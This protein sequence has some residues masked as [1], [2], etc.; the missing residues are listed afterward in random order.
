MKK[1]T[2]FVL[3]KQNPAEVKKRGLAKIALGIAFLQGLA[4][5]AEIAC[6]GLFLSNEFEVARGEHRFFARGDYGRYGVSYD[7]SWDLSAG[8]HGFPTR[9]AEGNF[10][11]TVG[12]ESSYKYLT[13]GASAGTSVSAGSGESDSGMLPRVSAHMVMHA[14]DS[15]FY[16]GAGMSRVSMDLAKIKWS[17]DEESDLVP[18]ISAIWE[19][20]LL[21]K[22]F[23]AGF[24]GRGLGGHTQRLDFSASYIRSTPYNRD[25][26]YYIRDSL[27]I[28]YVNASYSWN[29]LSVSYNYADAEGRLYGIRKQDNSTKRF[30]Y[31]P[32]SGNLH[33]ADLTYETPLPRLSINAIAAYGQAQLHQDDSRFH[34]TLAP[35]RALRNSV[36]QALSFSF[37]QQNYR[38]NANA[39]GA[40]G[41]LGTTY[42]KAFGDTARAVSRGPHNVIFEPRVSANFYYAQ[43]TLDADLTSERTQFISTIKKTENHLWNAESFGAIAGLGARFSYGFFLLDANAYQ[44]IPIYT[45]TDNSD[46][47]ENTKPSES[48]DKKGSGYKL[49]NGFFGTLR[50]GF[51]L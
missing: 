46:K 51:S 20:H 45:D 30:M 49:G 19:T 4:C 37:L 12:F 34:E 42:R 44:L 31:A 39:E 21:K 50:I 32:F 24:K 26:E 28:W 13:F 1:T 14:P 22:D 25:N 9:N 7:G 48:T 16:A 10:A 47:S 8:S 43:G 29:G 2:K 3:K 15:M 36:L 41:L 6:G 33:L 40:L 27:N 23:S 17:L 11:W 35:N 5:S 38:V 18:E